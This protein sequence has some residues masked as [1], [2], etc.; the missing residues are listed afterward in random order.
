MHKLTKQ[1]NAFRPKS[2]FGLQ[3]LHD[4]TN[5]SNCIKQ[6]WIVHYTEPLNNLSATFDEKTNECVVKWE[7][8]VVDTYILECFSKERDWFQ[9]R[10]L[11]ESF[12]RFPLEDK[13]AG[14]SIYFRVKFSCSGRES[15][16]SEKVK[17]TIPIP[18]HSSD[19]IFAEYSAGHLLMSNCRKKVI[20]K[21][22]HGC[23]LGRNVIHQGKYTW[24]V[25][26]SAFSSTVFRKSR[27]S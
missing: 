18:I 25:F 23:A 27:S 11:S 3:V 20:S 14:D 15:N 4:F 21:L 16:F 19:D 17:F 26:P 2:S 10:I 22:R 6:N 24:S 7:D 12:F 9:S 5:I 13:Q 1:L 8:R